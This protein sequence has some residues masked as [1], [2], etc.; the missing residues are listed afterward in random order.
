MAVLNDLDSF[1][2]VDDVLG[3][4]VYGAWAA[5]ANQLIC[6]KFIEHNNYIHQCGEELPEARNWD[7]Q[8]KW[9]DP[10]KFL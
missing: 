1:H 10:F 2:L 8:A 9:I 6:D 5:Y 7:W 4:A 3:R